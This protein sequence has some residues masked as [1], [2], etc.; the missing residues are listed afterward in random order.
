MSYG[1][2]QAALL[3]ATLLATAGCTEMNGS[4]GCVPRSTRSCSCTSGG[5][6]AQVCNADGTGYEECIGCRVDEFDLS[7]ITPP[8]FSGITPLDLSGIAPVDLGVSDDSGIVPTDL[9]TRLRDFSTPLVDLASADLVQ[10]Y[11]SSTVAAMRSAQVSG[12]FQINN[13]VVIAKTPS[14]VSPHL[15][16]QD[17][18][19]GDFSA[20]ETR[21]SSLST[22]HPCT[23][24]ST[25]AAVAVGNTVTL[26]GLY[27]RSLN[28]GY[29]T[30]YIDTVTDN[31]RV[32]S[33]PPALGLQ[34][35]DVTRNAGNVKWWFQ[36]VTLNISGSDP[37]VMYDF[38]PSE[39]S[40]A[41]AVSCPYMFGFGMIAQSVGATAGA[42][43]A[44]NTAQPAGQ[45][46]PNAAELLIGTDFYN[47][48]TV[49]SDCRCA[50]TYSDVEPTATSTLSGTV[51]GILFF[52][53]AV[54]ATSGVQYLAPTSL[55][56]ANITNTIP[57]M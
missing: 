40:N 17:A 14:V 25:V 34:L 29:E 44:T 49:S 51:G 27:A 10:V 22:V 11:S 32:S 21:C 42:A 52:E 28:N 31:G 8:D 7:G 54:S 3:A 43:C 20:I 37:L 46:S 2:W 13:V 50:K 15:I 53:A 45:S 9:A 12:G 5:S 24:A 18:A 56:D 30:F 36:K 35:S 33:T 26:K 16:V 41:G 38:T 57:G 47:P 55:A 39:L 6:G 48:F 4:A 19:G 1:N 23:V